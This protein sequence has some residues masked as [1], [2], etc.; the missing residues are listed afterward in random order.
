MFLSFTSVKKSKIPI[1]GIPNHCQYLCLLQYLYP[2]SYGYSLFF[3]EKFIFLFFLRQ[4][5]L[6]RTLHFIFYLQGIKTYLRIISAFRF[7]LMNK[8]SHFSTCVWKRQNF[9]PKDRILMISTEKFFEN[10]F[11]DLEL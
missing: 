8:S 11:D 9:L 5:S 7:S 6:C 1:F 2:S 4:K 3:Y 10:K